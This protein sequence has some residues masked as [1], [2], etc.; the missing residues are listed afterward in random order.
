MPFVPC[1]AAVLHRLHSTKP[2]VLRQAERVA[3]YNEKKS[4]K[5]ALIAKSSVL[6]DVKPWDDETDMA[7][8]EKQV[9]TVVMDGLLWGAGERQGHARL[10]SNYRRPSLLRCY[11]TRPVRAYLKIGAPSVPLGFSRAVWVYCA[12]N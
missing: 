8:L 11:I 12:L 5:A 9:R 2:C 10:P 4:K 1:T 6:L 7:E 3:A